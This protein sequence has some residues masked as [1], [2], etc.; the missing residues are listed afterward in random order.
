[1]EMF[2]NESLATQLKHL[3]EANEVDEDDIA[4]EM[5]EYRSKLEELFASGQLK[6]S[7]KRKLKPKPDNWDSDLD[8]QWAD[9]PGA[10]IHTDGED[11]VDGDDNDL[12]FVPPEK[13]AA[14]GRAKAAVGTQSSAASK[15]TAPASGR[16]KKKV[17]EEEEEDE[18]DEDVIMLDDDEEDESQSLFVKPTRST[19]RKPAAK[20]SARTK[21]PPKVCMVTTVRPYL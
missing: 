4:H 6:K 7:R 19:A 2:V 21:S 10:L 18:E 20:T 11:P 12:S 1:M 13:P 14:R 8:G 17:V 5:E 15:K 3:M 9:Q 16:G